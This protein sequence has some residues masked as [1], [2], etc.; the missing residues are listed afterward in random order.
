M[1]VGGRT[2]H[3]K[4]I[5]VFTQRFDVLILVFDTTNIK[6]FKDL[7][8]LLIRANP[9]STTPVIVIGTRTDL[10]QNGYFAVSFK[11]DPF[12]K[13]LLQK[14]YVVADM[15]LYAFDFTPLEHCFNDLCM[16]PRKSA[17][18]ILDLP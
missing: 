2:K 6:T 5:D 18:D 10:I 11:D 1:E 17:H 8:S 13:F 4:T 14:G 12:Y 9:D 16:A 3:D 15:S 7:E